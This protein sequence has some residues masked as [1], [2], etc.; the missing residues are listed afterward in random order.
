[1]KVLAYLQDNVCKGVIPCTDHNKTHAGYTELEHTDQRVLDYETAIENTDNEP[2]KLQEEFLEFSDTTSLDVSASAHGLVPKLPAGSGKYFD[3]DGTWKDVPAGV[4]SYNDL[5]DK[6]TTITTSQADAITSNT[7]K[8]SY[9][10]DDETKLGNIEENATADQT[11][12]EIVSAIDTELGN[13]DWKTGGSAVT[14][15]AALSAVSEN[16]V[17]NKVVKAAIDGVTAGTVTSITALADFPNDFIADKWM[18]VNSAGNAVEL[19]DAP[20]SSG[21]GSSSPTVVL[22]VE[23]SFAG[24]LHHERGIFTEDRDYRVTVMGE[25]KNVSN[26]TLSTANDSNTANYYNDGVQLMTSSWAGLYMNVQASSFNSI[27]GM[28]GSKSGRIHWSVLVHGIQNSTI[29]IRLEG[30]CTYGNEVGGGRGV[31]T[32][33]DNMSGFT[34]NLGA[35]PVDGTTIRVIV[36]AL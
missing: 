34:I 4:S 7:Q 8:R 30:K 2:K 13:T 35:F 15:D 23:S 21:G 22:D 32:T 36:E 27:L 11:G 25:T 24:G 31:A 10:A 26:V 3:N 17:Q 5:T 14:V 12:T 6:P 19:V 28:Y 29:P 16:P 1:M 33:N 9:P 20:S 18:K